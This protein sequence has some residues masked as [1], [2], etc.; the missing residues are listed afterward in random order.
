MQSLVKRPVLKHNVVDRDKVVIPPGWDSW[1]KIRVLR[2]GFD[3]EQVSR[4]WSDDIS[5]ENDGESG[6][7][8]LAI[9]EEIIQDPKVDITPSVTLDAKKGHLEVESLNSQEFLAVQLE[10]LD[11]IRS[12]LPNTTG[13]DKRAPSQAD[14]GDDS[15]P[16]DARVSEHIGPVQFNVGGIQMDAEDMLAR[17]KERQS[18]QSPEPDTPT[19]AGPDG[20][21]QNEA[22]ASFF[23]GLVKRGGGTPASPRAAGS[24]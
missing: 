6:A 22:L 11:R 18:H 19:G 24:S 4:G 16:V 21:S 5:A 9:F 2:D 8:A 12:T 7:S 1:G 23:A 14:A 13:A 10:E 15:G 3:V 17:L 20:K